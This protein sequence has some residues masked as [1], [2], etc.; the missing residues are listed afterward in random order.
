MYFM[1]SDCLMCLFHMQGIATH[2][3]A[4]P[5]LVQHNNHLSLLLQD[6]VVYG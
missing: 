4:V 1:L 2:L 3:T 5:G 6:M